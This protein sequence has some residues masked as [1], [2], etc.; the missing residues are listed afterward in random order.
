MPSD[1]FKI[2][3]I[4]QG[5]VSKW[6]Q[7]AAIT[8]GDVGLGALIKYELI[9]LLCNGMPGALGLLLRSKLY[10]KILGSVG[11]NVVFGRSL[12]LR[13][14]RKIRIGDNVII[15][16]NC[17]LDAKGQTNSGIDIGD[18]VFIG[19]NSIL[20]CKDG[21]M[22]IKDKV[23][24]GANCEIYSKGYLS[25][26]QGT[27][28]AA[29]SYLMCGGRYRYQTD[30]PLAAQSSYSAGPTEIG[31]N[32]WLGSKAVVLDNV[33]I[34]HNSVVGAGAVVTKSL[35]KNTLAMGVPAKVI[36]HLSEET[37]VAQEKVAVN[38]VVSS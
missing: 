6:K 24:I 5:K 20:Y 11:K 36:R 32:C 16:D 25:I 13:H 37:P 19:R 38:E 28:I 12:T 1:D 22:D 21:N 2:K 18:S 34:G 10:P 23:N 3:E 35:P 30:I 26:G 8:L 17:V 31:E 27:M 4:N 29:Y 14:P 9:L 33:S 7:Y 15:D